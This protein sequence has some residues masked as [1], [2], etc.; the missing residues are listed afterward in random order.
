MSFECDEK[1]QRRGSVAVDGCEISCS[2]CDLICLID[3]C[4]CQGGCDLIAVEGE[5]IHV[6][7]AKSG[8][9][10]R[11][12][13]E[14]AVR[15]LEECISKFKLDRVERRNLILIITYSKRLDG[16]ARNYILRE[17]PLRKRGYSIIYIRCGSDL[18]SMKF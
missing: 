12:D 1:C 6:I 15:Q 7:E 13:A 8:R 16:P 3:G 18:S 2:R 17:N 9:V 4:M 11:S 10:S 14:R 5:R